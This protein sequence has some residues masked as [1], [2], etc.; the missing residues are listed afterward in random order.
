MNQLGVFFIV[1]HKLPSDAVSMGQN[2][3][4]RSPP[5]HA[6]MSFILIDC[7]PMRSNLIRFGVLLLCSVLATRASAQGEH[8]F[9]THPAP[10]VA[11]ATRAFSDA[12][13]S[14][15]AIV[16]PA[17]V[18]ITAPM[19]KA[20]DKRLQYWLE[21]YG[22]GYKADKYKYHSLG[23]GVIL[24][25]D[26][27]LVTNNHVIEDADDDSILV[28]L[29]N[30]ASYFAAVIGTDPTTDLA[31]LKIYGKTF[32]TAYVGNSDDVK[33][34][35]YVLA[36]G[37]PLGLYSTVTSGIVSALGRDLRNEDESEDNI[38]HYIQTDAA[39]NPGNS[40][41]GL[42]NVEG[43]LIGINAAS[44]TGGTG[45][46]IGYGLAIPSNLMRAVIEDLMKDG[47]V[48]RGL[49]GIGTTE[50]DEEIALKYRAP[51]YKGVKVD[52]ID[53]GS[54]AETAGFKKDDIILDIDGIPIESSSKLQT[55]LATKKPGQVIKVSAWRDAAKVD[56]TATLKAGEEKKEFPKAGYRAS[57]GVNALA[58]GASDQSRLSLTG[59]QGALVKTAYKYGAAAKA[60]IYEDDVIV[61]AGTTTI[62][63]PDDLGKVL[64]AAKPGDVLK[65]KIMRKNQSMDKDVILQAA[66]KS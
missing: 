28:S 1:G 37:N 29:T 5:S 51:S 55:V 63:S 21:F 45:R 43:K 9:N 38:N 35:E 10:T 6:S 32:P 58:V 4:R 66:H 59:T 14:V 60:G 65:L 25:D 2:S 56:L 62:A 53:K 36:V 50:V 13:A 49:L 46:N 41:G 24:T 47:K 22:E 31:V 44:V 8:P 30:G 18:S 27:Y 17:V 11:A 23:S 42:F 39:I 15:S 54:A 57:L 26:G 64:D 52:D 34:G 16:A 48:H 40:G 19:G 7:D 33:V 3:I 20:N 61:Q 12:S